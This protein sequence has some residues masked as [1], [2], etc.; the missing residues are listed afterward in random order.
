MN[1]LL[2][3]FKILSDETRLRIISALYHQDLC[4]CQL[5]G[6][7]Q[8]SQPKVSK[9][10]AKLKD[11]NLVKDERK[12][13]FVFYSLLLDDENFKKI[14]EVIISDMENHPQL[15]SDKERFVYGEEFLNNCVTNFKF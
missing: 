7:L 10:L 1:D 9:N 4:V 6:I 2:N 8:L 13:K 15:K 12:E 14:V 11:L 5:T 3:I